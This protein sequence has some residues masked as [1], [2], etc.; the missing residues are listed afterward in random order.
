MAMVYM[1]H[2]REAGFCSYGLRQFAQT[3]GFDYLDFVQNGIDSSRFEGM[4]DEMIRQVIALA[5]KEAEGG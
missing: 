2:V 1:R 4:D 5:Q 3:H